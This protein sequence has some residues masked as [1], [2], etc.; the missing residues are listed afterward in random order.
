MSIKFQK[1]HKSTINIV[2]MTFALYTVCTEALKSNMAPMP[3]V[4]HQ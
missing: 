4:G 1:E 2:C 3:Q